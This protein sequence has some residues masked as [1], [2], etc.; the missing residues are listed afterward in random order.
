MLAKDLTNTEYF[1]GHK[2]CPGCALGIICRLAM[3]VC[4][5]KT[6][7]VL[8]ASC[9]S[10]VTAVY[11]QMSV[12]TPQMTGSFPATGALLNGLSA[13]F[14]AIG[15]E[16]VTVLGI[17][18]DGGTTDIGLQSLSGAIE[19]GRDF[20]YIC[21]DN[22]AY[23]NTGIQRSSQTPIGATTTTTP[24]GT[25]S[26]GEKT[27]KKN[28]FEIMIAHRIPYAATASVAYVNDFVTKLIKAKNTKGPAFIHIM[29]PCPTGWGFGEDKTVEIGRLAVEC[30]LWSLMEYQNGKVSVN[31]TAGESIK[32]IRD[33]LMAQ[34]RFRH[35]NEGNLAEI[36]QVRNE[37]LAIVRAWRDA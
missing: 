37:E 25:H 5:P 36:E 8:P 21:Y 3:K 32:P 16:G 20:L 18:G 34:R 31:L 1:Y 26:F 19:Q 4:G 28:L 7:L 13:G 22:E 23:M 12:L 2:A 6:M 29:A 33:Y 9:A 14:K 17:A 24:A 10:S 30:G 27:R 11:P 15:K 35:L